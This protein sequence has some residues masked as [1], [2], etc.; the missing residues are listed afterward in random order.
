MNTSKNISVL[1]EDAIITESGRV[2]RPAH[3]DLLESLPPDMVKE[4]A[5][6][7]LED[8][9]VSRIGVPKKSA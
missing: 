4:L 2:F 7:R 6:R 8:M 5:R 9:S 1:D 3:K